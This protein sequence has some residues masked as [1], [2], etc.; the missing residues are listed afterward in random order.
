MKIFLR[1]I[2]FL[3]FLFIIFLLLFCINFIFI[4]YTIVS[5]DNSKIYLNT[6]DFNGFFQAIK[7][8]LL[9]CF[10]MQFIRLIGS[11]LA[12][13]YIPKINLMKKYMFSYLQK[14][15]YVDLV[16]INEAELGKQI[17]NFGE[18]LSQLMEMATARGFEYVTT[19]IIIIFTICTQYELKIIKIFLL[20][21]FVF[22]GIFFMMIKFLKKYSIDF[23]KARNY[24][25]GFIVDS[26]KNFLVEKI[27]KTSSIN[28]T[29]IEQA[30]NK[31]AKSY[32]NLILF[33][34]GSKFFLGNLNAIFL[35]LFSIKAYNQN[36]GV[37]LLSIGLN[38]FI[39][40]WDIIAITPL[41]LSAHGKFKES[42][43]LLNLI[44]E[45]TKQS[46]TLETIYMPNLS[47]T[48]KQGEKISLCGPSGS[49]K[50]TLIHSLLGFFPS[51]ILIN[52]LNAYNV[53]IKENLTYVT[54]SHFLY[55]RTVLENITL[56]HNYEERIIKNLM[57]SLWLDLSL[58]QIVGVSGM[59]ISGGQRQKIII[60]RA[61][62]FHK[63]S[64]LVLLDEPFSSL[65]KEAALHIK[66]YL[67]NCFENNTVI[68]INHIED[69]IFKNS[70]IYKLIIKP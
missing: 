20:W 63:P 36:G 30:M 37:F 44:K 52:G 59:K 60:A 31:E 68:M 64:N 33:L 21:Q 54:Q 19:L 10:F 66:T 39:A 43:N 27:F 50:T 53:N 7:I 15:N 5:I 1:F 12:A 40:C 51:N 8:I 3:P 49:G 16:S 17:D 14:V 24:Q 65:D 35:F 18:G 48:I 58:D 46:I 22:W 28:Y 13:Y 69:L 57:E 23:Y 41:F 38:L 4:N 55:N 9:S 47:L 61:L 34:E 62:F 26:I 29:F 67:E 25:S 2:K 6:R 56:G 42:F 70:N 45:S 11:F 32:K